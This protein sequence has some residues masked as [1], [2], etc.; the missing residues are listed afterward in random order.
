MIVVVAHIKGGTGKTTTA[1]QIALHRQITHPDRKVWLVD[2]DDQQSALDTISIRGELNHQPPLACSAYSTAKQLMSQ[3]N[4]QAAIWDDVIIDCGGRDTETMRVALLAADKLIVPVLPRAYDVWSLSRLEAVIEA[5]KN[6]GAHFET[7]AFINRKDRSAEC[8]EAI[9]F[10]ESSDVYTL[11]EGSLT[12]RMA[13]AKAGGQGKCVSEMKPLDKKALA[14][15]EELCSE[16]FGD[17][18]DTQS[19]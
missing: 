11:M 10:L 14:E 9:K 18:E 16:I 3:M 6:Y 2:A 8:R 17:E 19:T 4:S 15:I 12:D 1:T 7:Y 13:Y 5:A